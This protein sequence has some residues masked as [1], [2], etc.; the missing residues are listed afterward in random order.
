LKVKKKTFSSELQ[1][2][3]DFNF[4]KETFLPAVGRFNSSPIVIGVEKVYLKSLC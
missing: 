3:E 4:S 1:N 2:I